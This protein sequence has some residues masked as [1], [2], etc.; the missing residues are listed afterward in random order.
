MTTM[1][2]SMSRVDFVHQAIRC[3]LAASIGLCGFASR[4][5]AQTVTLPGQIE[6]E[7]Y[8][9]G[10]EGVAY[11]DVESA[12][13]G[14]QYRPSEAVDIQATTDAGGGYNVGWTKSGEWLRY[15]VTTT[16]SG[17]YALSARVASNGPGG[18]FHVEI[19]GVNVTNSLTVADTGAWQNW[20]TITAPPFAMS[21]G[22][23]VLRLVMDTVGTTTSVGNFNWLSFAR[24][25]S[26]S[27][28]DWVLTW[29]D[30]FTGAANSAPDS[31]NW[32]YTLGGGG[33]G[34]GELETYTNSTDNV[35]LDGNGHLLITARQTGDSSY[36]S[37]RLD[38]AG[39]RQ[40][41]YGKIEARVKVPSTQGS[42]PAFWMLGTNIGTVQWPDCGEIDIME[43]V[44]REPTIN[45]GSLHGPGYSGGSPL[46]ATYT[47]PNGAHIDWDYHTFAIQWQPDQVMF[48]VDDHWYETRTPASVP[49]GSAWVFNHPFYLI[50][51][52]A[53]GGGF[54]GNPDS[55]SHFPITMSVDYIRAWS[56]P[57][58]EGCF[59]DLCPAVPGTVQTE[60]F[61]MGGEGVAYHDVDAANQGGG[62][63]PVE[64]VDL[65]ATSDVGGG[66]DLGWLQAG[67][68]MDYTIV[69]TASQ[70][71]TFSARVASNGTG[72]QFHVEVDGVPVT[73]SLTIPNTG[74]WQKWT[75][76]AS[77][78]F[79]LTAGTHV[80]KLVMDSNGATGSVGNINWI[81]LN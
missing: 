59:N 7:N 51:N 47:L 42:W 60:N 13:L 44:G 68:W 71:Y 66:F 34:N 31:T 67:E 56:L 49:A 74:G 9:A 52:L 23:H 22:Q 37:G 27:T 30:E 1:A 72:G 16:M 28:G 75:T 63:R 14:G 10:G 24:I 32:H 65:E 58:G 35:A 76:I 53:V 11:H 29:S 15:T 73:G 2:I 45:H 81:A 80:L 43:N 8:D 54:P 33:F 18:T 36:T 20:R 55:T 57:T 77:D 79:D 41:Q 3:L 62:Y 61:N 46:T 25:D 78:A 38:T 19:D 6:V 70:S 4:L 40:F 12:N 64:S 26:F 5:H 50:L 48:F 21:A 39:H 17:N 69:A